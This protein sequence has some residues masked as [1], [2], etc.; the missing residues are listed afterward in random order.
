MI[1]V[2]FKQTTFDFS[3]SHLIKPG[4]SKLRIDLYNTGIGLI[5]GMIGTTVMYPMYL[6]KRVLHANSKR[7][8]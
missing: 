4:M 6:L 5:S 2:A 1:F 7:L 3:R 8:F